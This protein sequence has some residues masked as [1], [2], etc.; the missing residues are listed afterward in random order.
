MEGSIV[1]YEISQLIL[2]VHSPYFRKI[3]EWKRVRLLPRAIT[4]IYCDSLITEPAKSI[5]KPVT[6]MTFPLSASEKHR[7]PQHKTKL[8][9]LSPYFPSFSQPAILYPHLINPSKTSQC[10]NVLSP[11]IRRLSQNFRD[12]LLVGAG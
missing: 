3:K 8:S 12:I 4:D 9:T 10:A 7:A 6:Q 1:L 2:I 11:L 5:Q